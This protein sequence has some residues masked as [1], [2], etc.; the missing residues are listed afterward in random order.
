MKPKRNKITLTD[1]DLDRIQAQEEAR[2]AAE[3][4]DETPE[5]QEAIP[6][7]LL[8][9]YILLSYNK[10]VYMQ[11]KMYLN[12]ANTR[13]PHYQSYDVYNFS[14]ALLELFDY[15]EFMI[16][17]GIEERKWEWDKDKNPSVHVLNF[18]R[19][20]NLRNGKINLNHPNIT[21]ILF[22]L[23]SFL[24]EWLH[25]LNLTNLLRQM[26]EEDIDELL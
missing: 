4:L 11:N 16:K 14:A 24:F 25:R 12:H 7:L 23:K 19:L 9:R 22:G 13:N 21:N 1:A 18:Q 15:L 10:V 26:H 3:G 6:E 2:W 5:P 8:K 17:Q 20:Q